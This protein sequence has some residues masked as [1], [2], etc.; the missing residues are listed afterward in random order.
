MFQSEKMKGSRYSSQEWAL[1]SLVLV[2]SFLIGA[3]SFRQ[4]SKKKALKADDIL[5]DVK[6][7]FLEEGPLDGSWIELT[8]VPW[9]KFAHKTDVYYGGISRYEENK[10]VQY[11][12]IADAYTGSII[13]IYRV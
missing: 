11:E 9:K 7:D 12:F 8:K 3:L 1:L 10:L 4:Y 2:L 6:K 13:D 5:K